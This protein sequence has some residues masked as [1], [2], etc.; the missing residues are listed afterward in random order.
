MDPYTGKVILGSGRLDPVSGDRI[1][2]PVLDP[3]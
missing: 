2:G 3:A 1:A